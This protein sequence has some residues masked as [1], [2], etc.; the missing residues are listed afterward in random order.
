MSV[1]ALDNSAFSAKSRVERGLEALR[2]V[3]GV[4][5]KR[6]MQRQHGNRW[7]QYMS[8]AGGS[9]LSEEEPDIYALLKTV[10]DHWRTFS[11]DARLRKARSYLSIAMD[12]RNSTA[13]FAGR[14][15]A[16]EAIRYLDAMRE[17]ALAVGGGAQVKAIEALYNEQF[18]LAGSEESTSSLGGREGPARKGS[19][20]PWR[21]V[22]Q[23][24]SDVLSAHFSDAEFA[25]NLALVD[26]GE[27]SEEYVDPAAFFRIT[28]ATEGL[29]RVLTAALQRLT[30]KGGE[31]VIGLQTSF[32]GGKTHAL[33]ALHHL[34]G[35][36][37]AN[38][39]P[40]DLMG[41]APVFEAAGATEL[42]RVRRAVFVGTHKGVA[43]A[44]QVED[45][46]EIRT[47]WGYLAWRLGGWEALDFIAG[48]EKAGTNPGSER[49][50][51]ILRAA[52]PCLILLDEVVAFARQLRGVEYDAFH[53]FIQSLTEA[54][55]AVEGAVVVGSLP[56]SGI[57]VGNEQGRHALRR[58]EKIFGR[59]QSTWMPASG[60]ETF[61]I[62]RRRLFQPLD[63]AGERARD[64]TVRAFRKLYR[65]N[66]AD[67]PAEVLE[68]G[69][70]EEMARAYPLHPDILRRFSGDWSVLEKF[71]RTRGI[72]KIMADVVYQLWRGE[73]HAPLIMPSLLPFGDAKVRAALVEPLD[74]AFLPILQSEVDGEQA[75]TARIEARRPRFAKARAATR[76][77][78]AVF[79]ATAP[80]AGAKRGGITGSELR[81]SC[82]QPGEQIALFGEALEELARYSAHLY[83][84][85]DS[86]WYSPN[87]TLNKLAADRGEDVTREDAD[88]RIVEILREEQ[89]HRAG[90]PR[91]HGPPDDLGD[92]EDR[93]ATA[94]V[95]LAPSASHDPSD[96]SGSPAATAVREALG[97][98]GS[99]QRS[100]QN[101]LM[102]VAPDSG[103]VET[104]RENARREMAW[105]SIL[106]DAE[107][108]QGLTGAQESDARAQARR[109][110]GAL[111]SSV[112]RAWVHV[113]HP[114]PPEED[115]EGNAHRGYKIRHTRIINRRAAKRIPEAVWD[116][117][118][119]DGTVIKEMGPQNLIKSLE[120]V[121]PEGQPHVPIDEVRRWFA[122]Y[123]HMPR[124]RDDATLSRAIE[125]LAGDL[126]GHYVYADS[127]NEETG[128]YEGLVVSGLVSLTG[129]QSLGLL[130]RRDA[131]SETE[132]ESQNQTGKDD[133]SG[134]TGTG[135][136]PGE[137]TKI[138]T[139]TRFFASI[140]V[141][142]DRAGLEVAEVMDAILVE[143]TRAQGSGI[144]VTLKLEG[145]AGEAGYPKDVVE[146]VEANA[147]D[148]KIDRGGFGFSR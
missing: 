29:K 68:K 117:V 104:A 142:P 19:L 10:F 50:I 143:L 88:A 114:G 14:M 79:F 119:G 56:E 8:R 59:V 4:Y 71:Q 63:Q 61:E 28:Y 126:V 15:P 83:R 20:T 26:Q 129:K 73:S 110:R 25:A 24:H 130:V 124:L 5:V 31:P 22:C 74:P 132:K 136:S 41:M 111:V 105:R 9:G 36:R 141:D 96:A 92:I 100:F 54:A 137:L 53:A 75:H 121:W 148:M 113:L 65:D 55:A 30:G 16:R 39:L 66:K 98:R 123:L 38:Y 146:T 76:A 2:V 109:S 6:M 12:A 3:L 139:L 108:M 118:L 17:V 77:A 33:L 138:K 89:H 84:N 64:R 42:G 47:L 103:S 52:A 127:F 106:D 35:A 7:R 115:V 62:V 134:E 116:R 90:I 49:M 78:R 112:R 99:G 120:P 1:Q 101:A 37:E 11:A 69:Y 135:P 70:A 145:K 57:E 60:I 97:R 51:P 131:L 27:G 91:V 140:P 86:Y 95:M 46:R 125:R 23:P 93:R 85:G 32:G 72:L 107:L 82:A 122:S 67:F 144:R 102:F 80:H 48:S 81:L 128:A 45:G 147:R 87:P 94:L 44:M 43:E 18:V 13:H 40:R 58:L 21:E 34:A 133:E